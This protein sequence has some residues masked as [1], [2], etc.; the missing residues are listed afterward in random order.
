[1]N[2]CEW[3]FA[4]QLF[5]AVYWLVYWVVLFRCFRSRKAAWL[6]LVGSAMLV[7]AHVCV[8]VFTWRAR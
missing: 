4:F 7:A 6:T 2:A 3:M 8:A 1:M 5:M